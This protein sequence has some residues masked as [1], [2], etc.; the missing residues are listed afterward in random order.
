MSYWVKLGG[1]D[2]DPVKVKVHVDGGTYIM[3]G[4]DVAELNVTYNYSWFY[5]HFLDAEHGLK[6]LHGRKAADCIEKLEVAAK[7]LTDKPYKDYW[8]PTPGN[9]GKA[10][11]ILLDW[12]KL[13]PEAVFEVD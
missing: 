3:G 1:A 9:A 5:H 4:T 8:A 10:L 13:H 2:G 6:W 12:A 11:A 7:E